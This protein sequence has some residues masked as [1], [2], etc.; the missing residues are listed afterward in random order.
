MDRRM[1]FRYY[2]FL[3][4]AEVLR[5]FWSSKWCN[6]RQTMTAAVAVTMYCHLTT[7]AFR[8]G[9]RWP[10]CCFRRWRQSR[11]QR[12]TIT[13]APARFSRHVTRRHASI[14]LRVRRA[15]PI[16]ATCWF[17][18]EWNH[19]ALYYRHN[20]GLQFRANYHKVVSD[21]YIVFIRHKVRGSTEWQID[22][23]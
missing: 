6:C 10:Q 9:W 11:L 3:Q 18:M 21:Y 23:I 14:K 15:K 12:L 17:S 4:Y 2:K 1:H 19:Y 8:R 13:G 7:S 22:H 16:T 20:I 5:S